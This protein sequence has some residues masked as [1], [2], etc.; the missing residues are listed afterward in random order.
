M[1]CRPDI[2]YTPH[3]HK[4]P[5]PPLAAAR[6]ETEKGFSFD[7]LYWSPCARNSYHIYIYLE[8]RPPITPCYNMLQ[9]RLEEEEDED[10]EEEWEGWGQQTANP[11]FLTS[12]RGEIEKRRMEGE[13]EM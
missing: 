7:V 12:E 2:C 6:T 9:N 3:T 10:E 13:M 11:A 4:E 8:H 5:S 1:A